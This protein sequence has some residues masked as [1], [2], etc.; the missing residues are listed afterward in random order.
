M[1]ISLGLDVGAVSVKLAA[2]GEPEDYPL[3]AHL[4]KA[5]S[6]FFLPKLP[7]SNGLSERPVVL[8]TYRSAISI[9]TVSSRISTATSDSTSNWRDRIGRGSR[10]SAF[11]LRGIHAGRTLRC[12]LLSSAEAP[13]VIQIG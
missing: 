3:L 13:I 5:S 4:A 6:S 8:S 12:R 11:T 2:L 10:T 1:G 9:L 7:K